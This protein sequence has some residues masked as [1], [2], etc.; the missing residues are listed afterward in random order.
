MTSEE[1]QAAVAR[2]NAEPTLKAVIEFVH[3]MCGV[4]IAEATGFWTE[5]TVNQQRDEHTAAFVIAME[6]IAP[7]EG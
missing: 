4:S 2:G 7:T 5:S 1:I 3:A 6:K